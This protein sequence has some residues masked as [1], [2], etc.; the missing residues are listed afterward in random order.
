MFISISLGLEI[1][2]INRSSEQKLYEITLY[3]LFSIILLYKPIV[4]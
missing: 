2:T 4:N 3:P 1:F